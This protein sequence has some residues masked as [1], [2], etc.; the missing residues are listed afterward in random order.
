VIAVAALT[1]LELSRRRF[2]LMAL[3]GTVAIALLT[4]WG[5][6]ALRGGGAHGKPLT[7]VE[8]RAAVA[9][10][11]PLIAYLFSFVLAF[12]AAMLGATMLTAEVESGVLLPVLARPLSRGAVVAGKAAGLG[13]VLCAYAAFSGLL[14]FA[15]VDATTG[16]LPPHPFAAVAGLAGVAL[17]M[18]VFSLALAS[19]LQAIASGIVAILCFGIAWI[20][21]ITGGIAS[22]Y[23]NETLVHAA[24]V[25]QLLLPT[26]VFWRTADYQLEPVILIDQIARSG[27]WGGPFW[28]TV[29]P[30]PAMMAWSVA[31]IAVVLAIAVWSF[32][33][34]DV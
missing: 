1:M 14:E 3:L 32:S 15:V 16:Y 11:L 21:G 20:A 19:R 8:A 9:A 5:F 31:W 22:S 12:A 29:P 13:I 2:A 24:T 25:A 17:V 33:T 18:L 23:Q 28:V 30:P 27:H 6:H 7:P 10:M 4:G 34:R 26:D